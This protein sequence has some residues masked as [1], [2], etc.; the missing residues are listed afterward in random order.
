MPAGVQ[1][2]DIA[3]P[4]VG[5]RALDDLRGDHRPVVHVLGDVH[6]HATIDQIVER[7]RGHVAFAIVSRVHGAIEMRADVQGGVD[8]LR[9]DPHGLQVLRVIHLVAGVS[10]PAR[11]MHVHDV[12]HVDDFHGG[13]FE[14]CV[15]ARVLV[16]PTFVKT[17]EIVV[18]R[19]EPKTIQRIRTMLSR[20]SHIDSAK[21]APLA[22]RIA[23]SRRKFCL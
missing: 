15:H 13:S 19:A 4:D 8:A 20:L 17:A 12:A 23:A 22:S 7:Q 21:A 10:H 16:R 3:L 6:H 2:E 11:R 18:G 9:H 5:T 14:S 1:D